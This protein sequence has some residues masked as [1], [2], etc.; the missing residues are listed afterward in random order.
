[1]QLYEEMILITIIKMDGVHHTIPIYVVK[2]ALICL[3]SLVK[4]RKSFHI[5]KNYLKYLVNKFHKF[6]Y[7]LDMYHHFLDMVL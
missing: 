6:G 4:I 3:C 5:T 7:Q 2:S 1:M